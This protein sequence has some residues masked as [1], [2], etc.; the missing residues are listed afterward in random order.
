MKITTTLLALLVGC[1]LAVAQT[2][3]G[4]ASRPGSDRVRSQIKNLDNDSFE[5]RTK[6]MD[7][8]RALG[9]DARAELEAARQSPSLEVRTRAETLLK[10][11]DAKR[12]PEMGLKK[13]V[14]PVTPIMPDEDRKPGATAEK[15]PRLDDFQDPRSYV[16]AMQK[17]MRE[18]LGRDSRF[19]SFV[20]P[21]GQ[22][23]KDLLESEQGLPGVRVLSPDMLGGGGQSVS[24]VTRNGETTTW[25]SGPGGV[26]VKITKRGEDGKTITEEYA[27]KD[28][29]TFKAEHPDVWEKHHPKDGD[30]GV[31]T[32]RGAS[33]LWRSDRARQLAEAVD[34]Q[35]LG[36]LPSPVPPVLDKQLKLNGDGVVVDSVVPGS[37]A[38]RLGIKDLDVLVQL[39]GQ[40]VRERGDIVRVLCQ[41][42]AP[43]TATAR[44]IR[45]GAPVE[46][47]APREKTR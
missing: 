38:D 11:L 34:Q 31:F 32:A 14:T 18:Q 17:W 5:L 39:D 24:I 1:G 28:E 43:P 37:L 41:K 25:K 16:E 22:D 26:N 3:A 42:D 8:L 35:K 13:A 40:V 45:E 33:P 19:P 29:E 10:D 15:A 27:A 6:A 12:A 46:L 23:L 9:E 20:L 44:V 21:D 2:E 30:A 36:V 47:S 4:A 7:E